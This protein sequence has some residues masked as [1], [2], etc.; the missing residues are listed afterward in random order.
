MKRKGTNVNIFK[1][2]CPL[3]DKFAKEKGTGKSPRPG[4]LTT[5]WKDLSS[6]SG[7]VSSPSVILP[8]LPAKIL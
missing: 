7:L 6:K 3:E 2:V 1:V 4:T 8:R 5:A